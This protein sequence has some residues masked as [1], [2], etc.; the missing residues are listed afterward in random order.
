MRDVAPAVRR[1]TRRDVDDILGLER[2]F[3]GDRMTRAGLLRLLR[4]PSAKIWVYGRAPVLGALVLLTRRGASVARIY[5]LVVE[6]QARGQGIG[7]QL[8]QTA[9]QAARRARKRT[10]SLEVREDNAAARALYARL[11]YI[12]ACRMRGYY[13]DGMDGLRL[14]KAL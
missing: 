8:V 11:G 3:P 5:S 12:E 2:H 4:R 9:E 7:Q 10:V 1:A 6:P 13:D 14:R